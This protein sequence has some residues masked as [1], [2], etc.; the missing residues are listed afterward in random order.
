MKTFIIVD[1]LW[2]SIICMEIILFTPF[3]EIEREY[4]KRK[5]IFK[6]SCQKNEYI[7]WRDE[8]KRR[9]RG[10]EIGQARERERVAPY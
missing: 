7:S 10:G 9:E 1:V 3:R 2:I 5:E 6:Q 8:F 4:P